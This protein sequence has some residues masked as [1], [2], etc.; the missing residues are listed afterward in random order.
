[1]KNVTSKFTT[2]RVAPVRIGSPRTQTARIGAVIATALL[3]TCGAVAP[4]LSAT[5]SSTFRFTLPGGAAILYGKA[6]NPQAPLSQRAWQQA[7]FQFPNGATFSLL[8]RV[9]Q[10]A[11][12]NTQ[13]E[14]PVDSNIS[15]SGEYVVIGRIES[16]SVSSGPGQAEADSSRE[17]CSAIEIRTGCITA[18]QTGEI[19]GA[20]WQAGQRAQWGTDEDSNVMLKR[21]RPSASRLLRVISAGQPA[22]F[23]IDNDSGAD[24]LLRCDPPSSANHA[25]YLKIATALHAAGVNNDAR[26]IDA[27]LS[28]ADSGTEGTP[29]R[30][31]VE[32]EHRATVSA[33]KASLY[34]APDDAHLSPAYLVQNDVVTIL[35]QS[36][37]DWAYV[38][39]VNGSGKHLLRWIKADQLTIKR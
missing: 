28:K 4:A 17:Y 19:C 24:N 38:D 37:P 31:A 15:S 7:I 20:G 26:L 22:R 5:P 2:A 16:G 34:T 14:P 36:P 35:K 8:P 6:S 30:T 1:L 27:A 29:T 11:S 23:V 18:D 25:A 21:D 3:L 9:G 39:Y 13:M 10:Q 33:R 12:G 32:T